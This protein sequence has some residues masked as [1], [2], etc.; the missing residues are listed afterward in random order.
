[1]KEE[2]GE[3]LKAFTFNVKDLVKKDKEKN[4][5]ELSH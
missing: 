4:G 3:K 5:K 1:M 2:N